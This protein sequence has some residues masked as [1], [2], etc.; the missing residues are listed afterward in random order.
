MPLVPLLASWGQVEAEL[1]SHLWQT[2][3]L[4]LFSNTLI[5]IA[6]VGSASFMLGVS[7]AWLVVMYDFPGRSILQWG[8]MLP[9][10]TRPYI[11]ALC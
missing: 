11:F 1:W 7:L 2:E 4:E 5:L 8:L 9:L 10:A 3:L 6:L